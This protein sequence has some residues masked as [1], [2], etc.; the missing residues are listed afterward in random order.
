MTRFNLDVL[1]YYQVVGRQ[2]IGSLL[3]EAH[4]PWTVVDDPAARARYQGGMTP[5]KLAACPIAIGRGTETFGGWYALREF[6][7]GLKVDSAGNFLPSSNGK[8]VHLERFFIREGKK[9]H[10]VEQS[11]FSLMVGR[12][13]LEVAA[14]PA[15]VVV[16][17]PGGSLIIASPAAQIGIRGAK[18]L[19]AESGRFSGNQWTPEAEVPIVRNNDVLRL[20]IVR[21]TVIRISAQ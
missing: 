21:P 12:F 6:C 11:P 14:S 13:V 3:Y 4:P 5:L 17:E 19:R 20:A 10:V 7:D 2:G 15:G 18:N 1:P 9:T 8:T 16:A